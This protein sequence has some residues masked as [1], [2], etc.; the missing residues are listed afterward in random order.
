MNDFNTPAHSSLYDHLYT[1][2]VS[3]VFTI[4][5]NSHFRIP[6]TLQGR[7][8]DKIQAAAMIDSGATGLFMGEKFTAKNSFPTFLLKQP[9]KIRNID[10]MENQAGQIES[11][12]KMKLTVD[13]IDEWM[14]WT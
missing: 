2:N 7:K 10:G 13:G 6:V 12:T 3:T 8:N 1:C 5:S 9:I 14:K 4:A 11:F